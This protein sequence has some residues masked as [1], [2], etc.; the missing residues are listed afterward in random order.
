MDRNDHDYLDV[1]QV[2]LVALDRTG[3]ITFINRKGCDLLGLSREDALGESWFDRFVPPGWRDRIRRL[4]AEV[5]TAGLAS[6]DYFEN[7]VLTVAG[8]E[9]L[10]AWHNA[11]LRDESGRVTGTLSSGDDIT[12]RRRMEQE[13]RDV[14]NALDQAAIVA[15]TDR[16]GV[17]TYVNDK[18]CEISQ[19][20]REELL[21]QDHR[22]INSGFH[23]K[24]FIRDLWR[25]IASGKI[26]R[27]E[28]R[29][30]AKDGSFYW[31]D[32]TIVPIL[33]EHGEPNQYLAIRS[34][35]TA[36]RRAEEE[37][38]DREALARLGQM[39]AVLAHEVRN[40]LAGIAGAIEIIGTRLPA[41]S[42]DREVIG[43]ILQRIDALNERIRDL[44]R[45]ARPRP[46]RYAPVRMRLLLRE[47]ANLIARDPKLKRVRVAISGEDVELSGD[48][49][50][51]KDVFSNL[52]I[53]AAQAM[54]GRGE[55]IVQLGREPRHC[56]VVVGDDGP[57]I[58]TE[59]AARM[60]EPFFTTKAKGTGLGLAISR[61]VVEA[62][63]GE[64]SVE[65]GEGGGTRMKVRLPL[66]PPGAQPRSDSG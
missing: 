16:R 59:V 49:E 42:P 30:R 19:Y 61:G 44:L 52:V 18:F 45:F 31:V 20:R 51:L 46:P 63:G 55:V 34:D 15:R 17:I 9:R 60:F 11:L 37:L 43:N 22:L 5:I 26:W 12:E 6:G 24:E 66:E 40:P 14:K 23:S 35:V 7:P 53:N 32:T 28:I 50:L 33:D 4:H 8:E 1:A 2:I 36:R 56:L 29:N 58:D 54:D 25:T 41:E 39:A 38:R 13:L 64:I 47:T 10:I 57:G 27:G 65:S 62:H 3:R 48:P 21:G